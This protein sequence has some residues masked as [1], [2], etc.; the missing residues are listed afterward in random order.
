MTSIRRA[1]HAA[2]RQWDAKWEAWWR[3]HPNAAE[4]GEPWSA[5]YPAGK[6]ATA[7]AALG[8][9]ALWTGNS[10]DGFVGQMWMRTNVNL[11]AA[12]AAQPAVLDLGAVN[13]E[14]ESSGQWQ[15]RGRHL[16]VAACPGT[17]SQPAMAA[18]RRQCHRHQY[19]LQLAQLRHE[20]GAGDPRHPL[21]RWQRGTARQSLA[22]RPGAGQ[23]DR[24]ANSL[25][26]PP[27]ASPWIITA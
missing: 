2:Q 20:R 21:C 1:P 9:W 19:F 4:P 18:C 26:P 10:P 3:G 24:A 27:M 22:I 7:P 5:S 14:D 12:Q 23:S 8:S 15:R 11:T 6:W 16:L 13:E 25:G 17:T